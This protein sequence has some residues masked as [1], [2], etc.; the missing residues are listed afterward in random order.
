MTKVSVQ[1]V[2]AWD[3]PTRTFHWAL[4][5]LIAGAWASHHYARALGDDMLIWHRWNGYAIL[6]LLVFR[7]LWG[8][9]GSSTSRFAN[10]IRGPVFALRYL[11]DLF[12]RRARAFLG[13]NPLG[14]W[15]ILLLLGLVAV[16]AVLG[17]FL[18]DHNEVVA[19]PLKRLIEDDLALRF[20]GWHARL[21]NLIL[22]VVG[23]HIVANALYGLVKKDPLIAAMVTGR[24][25]A[26]PY[27]DDLEAQIAP[28]I[29]VRALACLLAAAGVVFGG[30]LAAGGRL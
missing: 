13:H 10:F 2:R 5:F 18:L 30:I 14:T 28:H 4:V 1:Q 3:W 23:I 8:F 6:V 20:G 11:R 7:L 12:G 25:P 16:Q 29:A 15:M 17:L 27:E 19:G 21:F 9:V 24:K 26:A 22:L